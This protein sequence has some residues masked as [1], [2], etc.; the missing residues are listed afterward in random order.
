MTIEFTLKK[1]DILQMQ[2]FMASLSEQIRKTR[3]KT[4]LR[5]PI[6]YIVLAILLMITTDW[7]VGS[8][9]I[10]VAVVWYFVYPP[11]NAKHYKKYYSKYID[12][13]LAKRAGHPTE[14]T[15]GD[16]YIAGT[17]YSGE[18]KLKINTVERIDEVHDYCFLKFDSG[19]GMVIPL[20]QITERDSFI[21]Y[22]K[23]M[24]ANNNIPYETN[25]DW[26][27]R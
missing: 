4:H 23:K 12:E 14:I 22:L 16:E 17:D 18:S 3:R 25:M 20:N 19:V 13:N 1:D 21:E 27:W 8:V 9:F 7:A 11:Y 6:V 15:F 10:C 5:V 24:A 2:L 26:K